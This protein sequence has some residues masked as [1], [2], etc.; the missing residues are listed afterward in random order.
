VDY[1]AKEKEELMKISEKADLL[2][3]MLRATTLPQE[4]M[5]ETIQEL[6]NSCRAAQAKIVKLIEDR[7]DDLE[8]LLSLHDRL[9][10]VVGKYAT[11]R[12]GKPVPSEEKPQ[13]ISLI[14][15]SP[16][17]S[18]K[19]QPATVAAPSNSSPTNLMDDLLGLSMDPPVSTTTFPPAFS[20]NHHDIFAATSQHNTNLLDA[21]MGSI[22]LPNTPP[23]HSVSGHASPM[24]GNGSPIAAMNN[25]AISQVI[26]DQNGIEIKLQG[27]RKA[28]TGNT[29]YQLE[30]VF[31]NKALVPVTQL[32]WQLAGPRGA[33]LQLGALSAHVLPP[34]TA[35]A[36]KQL[37]GISFPN[38]IPVNQHQFKFKFQFSCNGV[39]I[40]DTGTVQL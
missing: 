29:T 2:N 18:P 27:N 6:Y 25:G 35:Q 16:T 28:G 14:S 26:Y 40:A 10:F 20:A 32:Q 22:F 30:C 7:D 19:S 13:E 36:S 31:S 3:Q 4:L 23:T 33:E 39:A 21:P 9:N 1:H 11:I 5:G 37:F 15:M 24:Q 17:T 34:A 12:E 38:S 8:Q